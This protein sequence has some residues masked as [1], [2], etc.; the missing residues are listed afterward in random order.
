MPIR[1]IVPI[2]GTK[3]YP[4]YTLFNM[5]NTQM[6]VMSK[7]YIIWTSE[8]EADRVKADLIISLLDEVVFVYEGYEKKRYKK[9]QFMKY[10]PNWILQENIE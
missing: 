3:S 4:A 2:L 7:P 10:N 1:S 6:E 8:N 9:S 5:D